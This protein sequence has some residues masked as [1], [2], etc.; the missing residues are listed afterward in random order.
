M[1]LYG[2]VQRKG[3]EEWHQDRV[4]DERHTIIAC[5][6]LMEHSSGRKAYARHG[7]NRHLV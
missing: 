4:K 3:K 1:L 6:I 5:G 2:L 7:L